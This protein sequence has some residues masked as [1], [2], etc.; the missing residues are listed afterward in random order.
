MVRLECPNCQRRFPV[1]LLPSHGFCACGLDYE[2]E[3]TICALPGPIEVGRV[4]WKADPKY[5]QSG[6]RAHTTILTPEDYL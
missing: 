5:P 6:T 2:L 4:L 3:P 1:L